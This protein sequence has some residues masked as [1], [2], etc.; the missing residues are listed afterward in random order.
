[1]IVCHRHRFIFVTTRK[2]AGTR[3]QLAL[4]GNCSVGDLVTGIEGADE[5]ARAHGSSTNS[6][7]GPSRLGR[8]RSLDRL[9]HLLRGKRAGLPKHM[10]ATEIR[11][12]VGTTIWE[13]YFTFCVERNPW[14]KAVALYDQRTRAMAKRPSIAEFLAKVDAQSL[15]NYHLYTIDGVLAVD[16][17]IRY[18]HLAA[19]LDAVSNLL[20]LEQP[21]ILEPEAHRYDQPHYSTLLGD[22]ERAIIDGVC[23]REIETF[24]YGFAVVAPEDRYADNPARAR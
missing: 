8:L 15:S 9:R 23:K 22:T 12:V 20:N 18:E 16:R 3:V 24:G 21:V 5:V 7:I 1:M 19:E 4:A 13:S 10:A 2:T 17:V 14:E 11:D 6:G